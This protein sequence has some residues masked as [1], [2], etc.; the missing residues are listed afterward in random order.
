M[1]SPAPLI[2][3]RIPTF[4]WTTG[5][6]G[7]SGLA[8]ADAVDGAAGAACE[9]LLTAAG[10]AGGAAGLAGAD[11][12]GVHAAASSSANNRGDMAHV[13]YLRWSRGSIPCLVP[14][15]DHG[16]RLMGR[17]PFWTQHA[18]SSITRRYMGCL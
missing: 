7:S 17:S 2:S 10:F 8:T 18:G 15:R 1:K 3:G 5:V 14:P 9:G 16:C 11:A 12:A 4:T 13:P 6:V